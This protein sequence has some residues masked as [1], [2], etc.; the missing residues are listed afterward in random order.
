VLQIELTDPG[1]EMFGDVSG[2]FSFG[3]ANGPIIMPLGRDGLPTYSVAALFRTEI[4]NNGTP[5]GVMVDSPA[6]VFAP[7][8]KGRVFTISPHSEDTPGLENFIPLA[9]AWLARK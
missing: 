2:R 5:V 4:A 6:A 3:Y 9:L 8:G 7:F 1:R